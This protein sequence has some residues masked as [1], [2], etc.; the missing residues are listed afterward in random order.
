MAIS[1]DVIHIL[2]M[3]A[4]GPPSDYRQQMI[5]RTSIDAGRSF[6]DTV[7]LASLTT[8]PEFGTLAPMIMAAAIGVTLVSLTTFR[9]K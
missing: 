9:R 7:Q 6:G 3:E 5:V 8:V 4:T 2:W 1:G